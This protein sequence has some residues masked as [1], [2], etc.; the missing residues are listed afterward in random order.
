MFCLTICDASDNGTPS[1]VQQIW[2]YVPGC[3]LRYSR[4]DYGK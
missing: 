1:R 3:Q 2:S 4:Y